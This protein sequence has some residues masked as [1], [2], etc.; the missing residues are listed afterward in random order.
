MFGI[1][2]V[3]NGT[4][5]P[6]V[7]GLNRMA[8]YNNLNGGTSLFYFAEIERVHAGKTMIIELFDPG[9]V[10]GNG[11]L[12]IQTPNG[13]AY[14]YATFSWRSDDGRSGTN[15]TQIQTSVS[16]AAQFN[17]RVVTIEVPLP[18]SYG[19]AGL[20]PPG[21]ATDEEGWWR[22]EYNVAGGNDTTTWRCQHPGQPRPPRYSLGIR[23]L[24]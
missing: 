1:Q 6:R 10:S 11:F 7:H 19:S 23:S 16:G 21:D 20:N 18:A 12:R 4:G 15:V 14:N 2:A 3:S 13:N 17:N 5:E 9:E 8:M 22:I 24:I